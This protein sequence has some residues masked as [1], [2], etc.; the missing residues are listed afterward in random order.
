M[1]SGAGS[2]PD[3]REPTLI[4]PRLL[5][6][7]TLD[8]ARHPRGQPHLSA[9]SG[10]V[11]SDS[12]LFLVADDEHHL[13]ALGLGDLEAGPLH[14][15]RI[16]PGD[17]PADARE[18]KRLKPDVESL[19]PL[20]PDAAWPG[21]AL[22]LLGSGSKPQRRRGWLLRLGS[23]GEITPG[24]MPIDL[25][26]LYA[27]LQAEF[28]DLNIEG[29]FAADGMFKL[30][31]RAN[32]G[33]ARNACID[34]SLGEVMAW[35]AGR[36]A[37]AP[38]PLRITP[39]EL[40]RVAGVPF[41]FTDGAALPGGRWVFSAVAE[42]TRDSY[43]DGACAGSLIG[44]MDSDGRLLGTEMLAG[45]PKVEGVAVDPLGRLLMVTDSDNPFT[46]SALLVLED[47]LFAERAAEPLTRS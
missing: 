12:S 45:A 17:L 19:A 26:A 4:H 22:L 24:V 20:P 1:A 42:D 8:P 32:A 6:T 11:V 5:R 34:Y 43:Q 29:G 46:P 30:L 36:R 28:P 37:A 39:Y 2:A 41:G 16:L 25:A 38:L 31:Q 44:W 27:P 33:A 47:A 10:L 40:G 14:L 35:L 13:A 21:G 15:H 23:L 7:L 9:A 18:R 3:P